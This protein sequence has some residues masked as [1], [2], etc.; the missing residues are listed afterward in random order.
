MQA[1]AD[2]IGLAEIRCAGDA[3]ARQGLGIASESRDAATFATT[4]ARATGEHMIASERSGGE[5]QAERKEH[6]DDRSPGGIERR[7]DHRVSAWIRAG[8]VLFCNLLWVVEGVGA[9]TP[10][11]PSDP[12]T[13][14]SVRRPNIVLLNLDDLSV[15]QFRFLPSIQNY[16]QSNGI[17]FRRAYVANPLCGPSRANLLTA[18]YSHNTRIWFNGSEPNP[19]VLPFAGAPAFRDRQLDRSTIFTWLDG[20]GYAT[21]LIGKAMNGYFRI[22]PEGYTFP[23]VDHWHAFKSDNNNYFDYAL[24]ERGPNEAL[25]ET[26]YGVSEEDYS[27]DVLREKT[28]SLLDRLGD[29]PFFLYLAP[30]TPHA[31]ATPAPR[32]Q[33]LFQDLLLPAPPSYDEADRSDK[34]TYVQNRTWNEFAV[35]GYTNLYRRAAAS[36]AS[37]DEMFVALIDKLDDRDFLQNTMIIVLSD[38]GFLYGQ[39]GLAEKW[40]PYLESI[41]VPL[42][43]AYPKLIE[44]P[45]EDDT[46]LVSVI[47][48]G[49]TLAD[50][51]GVQPTTPVNGRS[52]LPLLEAP[53]ATEFRDAVLF[54]GQTHNAFNNVCRDS[55]VCGLPT[56]HGLLTSTGWK[57]VEYKNRERELYDLAADPYEL[58]NVVHRIEPKYRRAIQTLSARLHEL[59]GE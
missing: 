31:A 6:S 19:E 34:P 9:Q 56:F 54:E 51:V 26:W 18:R 17:T 1:R 15:E 27:T 53:P 35:E 8:F 36:L 21:A 22:A 2:P 49:A 47:D 46:S 45:R 16:F 42:M 3:F 32:H 14:Q 24:M 41:Q 12:G 39:H 59:K 55:I 57:Y 38:N 52:L 30:F 33:G 37:V 44:Y 7:L 50:L 58:E 23:G 29:D 40:T 11:I 48:I 13:P 25:R 20:A 43:I 10:S 5:R 4:R 28:L